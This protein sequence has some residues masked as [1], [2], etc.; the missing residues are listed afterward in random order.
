M[1]SKATR[2]VRFG[3]WLPAATWGVVMAV[4]L[5]GISLLPRPSNDADGMAQ[6]LTS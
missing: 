5:V 3:I 4:F 1:A 2:I 6:L